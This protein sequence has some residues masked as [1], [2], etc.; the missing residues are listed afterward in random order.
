M[1]GGKRLSRTF[2]IKIIQVKKN[3]YRG[4]ISL[5]IQILLVQWI[6]CFPHTVERLYSTGFYRWWDGIIRRFFA[7]FSFSFGDVCYAILLLSGLFTLLRW[8][9]TTT[10]EKMSRLGKFLAGFYFFFQL[11]W[12]LNYYRQPLSVK[13]HLEPKY[14][15]VELRDFTEKLITKTNA[16]QLN[17]TKN[18]NL[19]VIVPYSETELL[20]KGIE[21]YRKLAQIHPEINYGVGSVKSSLWKTPLSYMGFSGYL[22]PFTHEAQVNTLM[23][24]YS[25]SNVICHEM[26]HQTGLASESE[27]NF[28]GFLAGYH[29]PDQYFQYSA[30][31]AALKYCMNALAKQNPEA[32]DRLKIK[33]HAGV[34]ENFKE[35]EQFWN[36][37]DT[38]IDKGFHGFYDRFLK[39]NQQKDGMEGY[40]KFV[41]LL[42]SYETKKHF[43]ISHPK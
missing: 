25:Q 39:I 13:W 33:I 19:K 26:A 37:Y 20:S 21:G 4:W 38:F 5:G 11:S 7:Y 9:K 18:R 36:Q 14:T 42:I 12:G 35:S 27:C 34:L 29:H 6:A 3:P 24:K 8:K 31:T 16:I 15:A 43:F 30:C 10:K 23:P 17:I 32:F 41:G 1:L 28:I 40:S 22:N 2:T